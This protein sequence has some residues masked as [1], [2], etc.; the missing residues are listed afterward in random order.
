MCLI[1]ASQLS[2]GKVVF[3]LVCVCV[4]VCPQG[5]VPCD[6]YLGNIG[7]HCTGPTPPPDIGPH[8][9]GTPTPPCEHGTSLYRNPHLL[10]VTSGG[11]QW[12]SVQTVHFR[13]P[14]VDI[15]PVQAG[16]MHPT[17]MLSCLRQRLIFSKRS[18]YSSGRYLIT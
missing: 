14:P 3:S 11:N 12:R 6:H 16:S 10:L 5:W 7:P 18:S 13:T 1:T 15:S 8:C 2:C 17:G 9:T 4:C